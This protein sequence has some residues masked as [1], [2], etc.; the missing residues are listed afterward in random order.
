M[1]QFLT[2]WMGAASTS[3]RRAR[4]SRIHRSASSSHPGGSHQGCGGSV[5][6]LTSCGRRTWSCWLEYPHV[7]LDSVD[8]LTVPGHEREIEA[9]GGS[10]VDGVGASKAKTGGDLR[11]ETSELQIEAN[12][13]QMRNETQFLGGLQTEIDHAGA[14]SDSS[15]DLN[16]RQC[17]DH[18]CDVMPYLL[19]QPAPAGHVMRI[20]RNEPAHPDA[21]VDDHQRSRRPSRMASTA[22]TP[23]G[24]RSPIASA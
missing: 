5:A 16:Q 20:R 17:R 14:P 11:R 23:C 15:R 21:G 4:C 6:T 24:H 3:P 10:N 18:Q 8:D 9:S 7:R 1:L 12:N 13:T 19:I 2:V 22:D